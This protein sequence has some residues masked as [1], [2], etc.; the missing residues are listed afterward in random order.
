MR[1]WETYGDALKLILTGDTTKPLNPAQQTLFDRMLTL[2]CRDEHGNETELRELPDVRA[3]DRDGERFFFIPDLVRFMLN[4]FANEWD[5]QAPP[6]DLDYLNSLRD[7]ERTPL[8]VF[9]AAPGAKAWRDTP[10][11]TRHWELVCEEI[12]IQQALQVQRGMH[13]AGDP[14]KWRQIE[15]NV[16]ELNTRL[17]AVRSEQREI[18]KGGVGSRRIIPLTPPQRERDDWPELIMDAIKEFEKEHGFTGSEAQIWTRLTD[19]KPAGWEYRVNKNSLVRA[20]TPLT[21][22]LFGERFRR[23]YPEKKS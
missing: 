9:S 5:I 20:G 15:D 22:K 19:K 18:E 8:F 2:G 7:D 11:G 4:E 10:M 17:E 21:R 14:G 16:H 12:R 13:H 3:Q 23:M 6:L 1:L